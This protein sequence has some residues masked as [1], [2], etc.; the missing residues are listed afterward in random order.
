MPATARAVCMTS[1][2]A[3]C[4]AAAATWFGWTDAIDTAV[5]DFALGQRSPWF[6]PPMR[7]V[8]A[9]F[10]PLAASLL[11]AVIAL[12]VAAR[13]RR[14]RRPLLFAAGVLAAALAFRLVKELLRHPRPDTQGW[15]EYAGGWS[16]PSGHTT[17]ATTVC[18]GIVA[19]FGT[20]W[21][22]TWRRAAWVLAA[23]VAAAVGISRIYL[24]VHWLSDV[25]GGVCLGVAAS[26]VMGGLAAAAANRDDRADKAGAGAGSEAEAAEG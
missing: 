13:T 8:S 12:C 4:L 6:S 9:V 7:A 22:K 24:G 18:L 5:H 16:F 26:A 2:V 21:P 17:I 1:G 10:A 25:V 14:W 23:V 3:F 19:V 15:L 11:T 20:S